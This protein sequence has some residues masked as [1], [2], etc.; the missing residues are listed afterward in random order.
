MGLS[1]DWREFLELL[2]SPVLAASAAMKHLPAK[3]RQNSMASR[4]LKG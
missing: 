2:N 3:F 1:K 4:F